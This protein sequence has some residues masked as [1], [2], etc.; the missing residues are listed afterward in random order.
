MVEVVA[1]ALIVVFRYTKS[2]TSMRIIDQIFK[3]TF[4][5]RRHKTWTALAIAL[6]IYMLIF[7]AKLQILDFGLILGYSLLGLTRSEFIEND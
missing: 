6:L 3:T 1:V 4:Q 7:N 5:K 2:N